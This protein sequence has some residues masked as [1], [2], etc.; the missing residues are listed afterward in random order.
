MTR[1]FLP[2][3]TWVHMKENWSII[4]EIALVFFVQR[5]LCQLTWRQSMGNKSSSALIAKPNFLQNKIWKDI[6]RINLLIPVNNAALY[7]VMHML[8]KATYILITL[9]RSVTF[10]EWN[11]HAWIFT[12]KVFM[13]TVANPNKFWFVWL[14]FLN[15]VFSLRLMLG[16]LVLYYL[17]ISG[18]KTYY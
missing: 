11:M 15:F 12:L 16:D 2:N 9:A 10:V 14:N 5:A 1:I 3:L 7:F 6:F 13:V 17:P 8:W 4:V 18:V